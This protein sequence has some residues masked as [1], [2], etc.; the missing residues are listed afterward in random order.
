[1]TYTPTLA[2]TPPVKKGY[3]PTLADTPPPR[4]PFGFFHNVG[5]GAGNFWVNVG[6]NITKQS[7]GMADKIF[8]KGSKFRQAI[9]EENTPIPKFR[10]DQNWESDIGNI[11]GGIPFYAGG[12]GTLAKIGA[13]AEKLI[14]SLEKVP[15]LV[16]RMLKSGG[17]TGITSVAGND[18][19]NNKG[20]EFAE[21]ALPG[22]LLPVGGMFAN[23]VLTIPKKYTLNASK[24]I[25]SRMV[26]PLKNHVSSEFNNYLSGVNGAKFL[27]DSY[28]NAKN[29]AMAISEIEPH[30]Q[31]L[32]K[33]LNIPS[34]T[35]LIAGQS[36]NNF[37]NYTNELG[38]QLGDFE[39]RT[40]QAPRWADAG[41]KLNILDNN[42]PNSFKDAVIQRQEINDMGDFGKNSNIT[43]S[44]QS[45]LNKGI[46]N[47]HQ[48]LQEDVGNL[49]K[50]INS[51]E[52]SNFVNKWNEANQN[53]ANYKQFHNNAATNLKSQENLDNGNFAKELSNYVPKKGEDLSKIETLQQ[54]TGNPDMANKAILHQ[55]LENY[56]LP[57]SEGITYNTDKLANDLHSGKISPAMAAL[58]PANAKLGM[59]NIIKSKAIAKQL[60][61]NPTVLD[62]LAKHRLTAG[63]IGGVGTHLL[64][65]SPTA[66]AIGGV[67]GMYAPSMVK[68]NLSKAWATQAEN[69]INEGDLS[70]IE[71]DLSNEMNNP[72]SAKSPLSPT[73]NTNVRRVIG[74]AIANKPWDVYGL[75]SLVSQA[76]PNVKGNFNPEVME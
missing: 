6:N 22:A 65:G 5:A 72:V 19:N 43:S 71:R 32:D 48:A 33:S 25:M 18:P 49:A 68:N 70:K 38:R 66:S 4:K 50:N 62:D 52:A 26:E 64:G 37:P 44:V 29:K 63:M 40:E 10:S 51:P 58:M 24:Q 17:A 46:P 20:T 45:A 54:I 47:L 9:D 76:A 56:R 61:E 53:Y 7:A 28:K 12:E 60:K 1:M 42:I 74:S 21:A 16:G 55:F 11:I 13:G 59:G 15:S 2:D 41:K 69:L 35:N 57:D 8:P 73:V 30:A 27:G 75:G 39:D 34:S 3:T 31:A 23:K 14:P 36:K 67:M